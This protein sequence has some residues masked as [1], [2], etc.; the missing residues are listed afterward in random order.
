M[1]MAA[2]NASRATGGWLCGDGDEDEHERHPA[3]PAGVVSDDNA[4]HECRCEHDRQ[5]FARVEDT[6]ILGGVSG[7]H[8]GDREASGGGDEPQLAEDVSEPGDE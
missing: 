8:E 5:A 4:G 1:R 7:V 2:G 6:L 3:P